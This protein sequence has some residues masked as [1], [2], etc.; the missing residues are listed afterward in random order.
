[1]TART[2][3]AG[4]DETIADRAERLRRLRRLSGIARL[5]DTA[6]GIPGTRIRF[7]ADSVFGLIPL[8]GDAGGALVGLYIVNEARKLGL[9]PAKLTRM[10]G[11]VAA[12]S[13]LGSVPLAGDVF[14]LFFKSHRRNVKMI[15]EHFD[16]HPDELRDR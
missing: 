5:M 11:N 2:W 12:D 15:L 10:L 3:D 7:G 14:D 8:V 1:M 6:I 9:P 4:R 16:V 13:L